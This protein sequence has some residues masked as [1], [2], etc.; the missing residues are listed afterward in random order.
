MPGRPKNSAQKQPCYCV[1]CNGALMSNRTFRRHLNKPQIKASGSGG[2]DDG[3]DTEEETS[4]SDDSSLDL[5]RPTKKART[6]RNSMDLVCL[7]SS[8]HIFRISD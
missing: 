8:L 4:G 1:T 3:R 6:D 7:S 2:Y 5:N